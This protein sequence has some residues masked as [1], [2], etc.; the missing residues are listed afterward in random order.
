MFSLPTLSLAV[1]L[2]LRYGTGRLM[3][4]LRRC[5]RAFVRCT[6]DDDDDD[7]ELYIF[8]RALLLDCT[9]VRSL[10]HSFTFAF[11]LARPLSL[12]YWRSYS[13]SLSPARASLLLRLSNCNDRNQC[14]NALASGAAALLAAVAV[15][16]VAAAAAAPLSPQQP[17][18]A[19]SLASE[20]TL[21]TLMRSLVSRARAARAQPQLG[22][23]PAARPPLSST[24]GR[25]R[26][27]CRAGQ[28]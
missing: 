22:V 6:T 14:C 19:L 23:A 26:P 12:S 1:S 17:K 28:L 27:E 10:V 13:H 25:V 11:A 8:T 7:T 24:H 21:R 3:R 18:G 20:R 15:A 5:A 9:S 2:W 4:S 16:A